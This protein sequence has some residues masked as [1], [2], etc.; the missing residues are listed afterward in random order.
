M[1]LKNLSRWLLAAVALTLSSFATA[2]VRISEF[3][4]DNVGADVGESV[5]VSAPAGTDLGNS[6]SN[7][8]SPP[9]T[10]TQMKNATAAMNTAPHCALLPGADVAFQRKMTVTISSTQAVA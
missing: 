4:Y 2:Q 5:E 8:K 6:I 7:P 10:W 1:R 9:S 3:H